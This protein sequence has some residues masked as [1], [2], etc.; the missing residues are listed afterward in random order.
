VAW[1]T[2]LIVVVR[3]IPHRIGPAFFHAI[4][5]VLGLILLKACGETF[6]S[7]KEV[8]VLAERWRIHYN[9]VRP[10]ASLWLPPQRRKPGKPT[11]QPS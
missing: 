10:H 8:Q 11:S 9:T 7:L 1:L 5:A 6:Y 4:N 3:F 2:V